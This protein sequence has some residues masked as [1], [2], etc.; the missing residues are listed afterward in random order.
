MSLELL[1]AARAE[2]A[3]VVNGAE[4]AL[5]QHRGVLDSMDGAIKSFEGEL[6]KIPGV[7]E[8]KAL[9]ARM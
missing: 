9:I 1:K 8:L 7:A 2:L 3:N 4:A 6:A 5:A